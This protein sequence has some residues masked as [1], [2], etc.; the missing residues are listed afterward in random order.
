M[1]T[2]AAG[3]IREQAAEGSLRVG[4]WLMGIAAV[5]FIG[6]AVIFFGSGPYLVM[7]TTCAQTAS[8]RVAWQ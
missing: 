6:Y 7:D 5:S 1:T 4:S 2:R 3:Q 8:A